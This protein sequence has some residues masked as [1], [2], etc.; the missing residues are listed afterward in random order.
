[1]PAKA[2]KNTESRLLRRIPSWSY[3]GL[4]MYEECPYQAKLVR[5]EGRQKPS[6]KHMERGIIIHKLAEDYGNGVI[7]ADK[8][9]PEL[10]DFKE[11]FADLRQKVRK[12]HAVCEAEFALT[13]SWEAT[14]WKGADVWLRVKADAQMADKVHRTITIVDHKTGKIYDDNVQQLELYAT[15]AL[16]LYD[17]ADTVRG[18]LW[19]LDQDHKIYMETTRAELAGLQDYWERRS[20]PMLNDTTFAPLPG[21]HCGRCPFSKDK[22]GPC[23]YEAPL[24]TPWQKKPRR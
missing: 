10:K 6:S 12:G 1:M 14:T 23:T 15:V 11:E 9:P 18:E 4:K 7:A 16:K 13:A 19:Y 20:A 17:W 5:L 24:E 21:P 22:G 2:K 3:S 8:L